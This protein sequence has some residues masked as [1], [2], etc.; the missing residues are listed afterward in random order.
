ML[1]ANANIKSKSY[2]K[3]LHQLI[4]NTYFPAP[5]HERMSASETRKGES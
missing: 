3:L 2:H 5:E 1:K 4:F